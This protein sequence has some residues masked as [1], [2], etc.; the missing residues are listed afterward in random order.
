MLK[1]LA[2]SNESAAQTILNTLEGSG[3]AM[4][5]L[6]VEDSS[7]IGGVSSTSERVVNFF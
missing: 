2:N 4:Y 1:R 6:N 5:Q 7:A 3:Y